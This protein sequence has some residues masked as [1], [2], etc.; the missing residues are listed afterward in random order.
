MQDPKLILS[1]VNSNS[2]ELC[3]QK[4]DLEAFNYGKNAPPE[5]EKSDSST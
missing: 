4:N 2:S 5:Y 3:L 1:K